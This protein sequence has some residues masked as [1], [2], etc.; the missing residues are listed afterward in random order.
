MF[1]RQPNIQDVLKDK[2]PHYVS[3]SPLK[4]KVHKISTGGTEAL[5]KMSN[6]LSLTMM[7]R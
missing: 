5:D 6:D 1:I 4:D 2:Y 7:L 3:S